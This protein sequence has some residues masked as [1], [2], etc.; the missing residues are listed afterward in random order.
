MGTIHVTYPIHFQWDEMAMKSTY[1]VLI[2]VVISVALLICYFILRLCIK[3]NEKKNN[4]LDNQIG[5]IELN[6]VEINLFPISRFSKH[7]MYS[8]SSICL[9]TFTD[10]DEIIILPVCTHIYHTHC[11]TSWFTSHSHCPLF[12]HNYSGYSLDD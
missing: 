9:Q 4:E 12:R 5:N 11:I 2:V 7:E 6:R 1:I 8:E 3:Y 10:G